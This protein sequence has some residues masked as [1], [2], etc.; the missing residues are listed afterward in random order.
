MAD[1]GGV[2]AAASGVAPHRNVTCPFFGSAPPTASHKGPRRLSA[3]LSP[4][5]ADGAASI[6][7]FHV[8]LHAGR[9]IGC[10][11][12][13]PQHAPD[14]LLRAVAVT[15]DWRDLD[16]ATRLVAALLIRARG[17]DTRAAYLLSS[18]APAYFALWG[19]S[20][21][22]VEQVPAVVRAS[23]TFQRCSREGALCMRYA[24]R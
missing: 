7:H 3:P 21:F 5:G 13:E 4:P 2:A 15:P 12:T 19:F 17:A 11:A 14:I 23:S 24:L 20:L 8:A 10:A 18:S 6:A 16:V 1:P 22:P 9:L